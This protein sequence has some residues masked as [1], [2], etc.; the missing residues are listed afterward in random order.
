[1]VSDILQ[2]LSSEFFGKR[3]LISEDK[4]AVIFK[5]TKRNDATKF[6]IIYKK[7]VSQS[8][9]EETQSRTKNNP[10]Y[11]EQKIRWN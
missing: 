4:V 9:T 1:M 8:F 3:F 6:L 2:E 5:R 11:S 10:D 7:L